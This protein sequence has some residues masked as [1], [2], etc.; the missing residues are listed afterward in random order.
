MKTNEKNQKDE[1][2]EFFSSPYLCGKHELC[3]HMIILPALYG[4]GP[5]E[6]NDTDSLVALG[7]IIKTARKMGWKVRSRPLAND[8]ETLYDIEH[9]FYDRGTKDHDDT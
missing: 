4:D 9:P 5:P 7:K 1:K 3:I 6:E 8:E 2:N